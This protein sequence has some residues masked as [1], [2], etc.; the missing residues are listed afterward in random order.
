L[1]VGDDNIK[2]DLLASMAAED[3]AWFLEKAPGAYILGCALTRS[4][5]GWG[6]AVDARRRSFPAKAYAH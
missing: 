2:R 1:L 4:S 5:N 6:E 3:F